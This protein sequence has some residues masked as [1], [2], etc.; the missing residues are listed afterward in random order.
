LSLLVLALTA[1]G[2]AVVFVMSDSVALLADLVHNGGDALTAIPLGAAF[3][4]RSERA[5][6]ASGY[7][8]VAVIFVSAVVAGYESI[9]RLITPRD[10]NQLF[11]LGAAGF[12]GFVGNEIAAQ[13]RIRAGK[14][15]DS[16]ALMADGAHA[17]ADGFVSLGVIASAL[18]VAMGFDRA[19]PLIG[20]AITAVI[21]KVTLD[22]WRTVRH[23][24][25]H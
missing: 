13:I 19:D 18:V 17:R 3:L 15:L 14:R 9:D 23:G 10:I 22:A 7:F 20:L 11:A 2:Q 5:E 1:V 8:V 12:V 16:P 4:L 6:R 25:H 24:H 21:L